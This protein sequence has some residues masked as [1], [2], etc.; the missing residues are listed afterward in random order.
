[1]RSAGCSDVTGCVQGR[2]TGNLERTTLQ[3]HLQTRE[4]QP[5][6]EHRDQNHVSCLDLNL[7]T[8]LDLNLV[9][10][11]DLN[12]V[13]HLD[14]NLVSCLDLNHLARLDLNHDFFCRLLL[15]SFVDHSS[16]DPRSPIYANVS[17]LRK[18]SLPQ[19]SI[20]GPALPLL[21]PPDHAPSVPDAT[22][23]SSVSSSAM[24]S[25]ASP[26]SPQ[27]GWQNPQQH[28]SL[29]PRA[30]LDLKD[31][32]SSQRLQELPPLPQWMM[33]NGVPEEGTSLQVKN[34]RHSVAE[35][36]F[37]PSHRRN[38]SD[39]TDVSSRRH[40]PDGPQLS[41]R[42]RLKRNLSNRSTGSHQLHCHLLEKAGVINKTKVADNGKKIR[43]NWSQSW[44]VLHGGI[45]TFH[46]D[47]KSAP[48]GNTVRT[49]TTSCLSVCL[50]VSLT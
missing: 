15:V 5:E 6:S 1:M 2:R 18:T 39:F 7:V 33:G 29:I 13:T 16:L 50:P 10:C 35:D 32:N 14:L 28:V 25:P 8:H 20:S 46:K 26:L 9:S 3:R 30:Q 27:D 45:L 41:D 42:H 34:W 24:I 48:T 23:S 36:T 49:R 47:P 17:S 21:P 12:L 44:T 38:V 31:G 4:E 22:P 40:S 43:K 19:I 11:L 37:A